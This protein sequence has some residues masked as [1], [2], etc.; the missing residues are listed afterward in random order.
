MPLWVWMPADQ[1]SVKVIERA[2]RLSR[3]RV[4]LSP[5]RLRPVFSALIDSISTS[6]TFVPSGSRSRASASVLSDGRARHSAST[7]AA[8]ASSMRFKGWL[9][10][11]PA[12]S[13]LLRKV[14][15]GLRPIWLRK[16]LLQK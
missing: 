14:N 9:A 16:A 7:S 12:S 2:I 10:L 4:R 13:I 6:T 1:A 15:T 5:V 3:Q 11:L 8:S